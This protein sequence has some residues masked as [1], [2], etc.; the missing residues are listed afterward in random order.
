ME[1]GIFM[2]LDNNMWFLKYSK[3]ECGIFIITSI[4]VIT[5]LINI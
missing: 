5:T 2:N 4:N 1:G 3:I